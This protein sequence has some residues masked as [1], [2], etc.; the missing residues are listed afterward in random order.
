MYGDPHHTKTTAIWSE[1]SSFVLDNP[2]T[3]T[4]CMGDLNSPILL[5]L[6]VLAIFIV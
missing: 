5:M 2:G 6:L 3:P 1:V 4:F